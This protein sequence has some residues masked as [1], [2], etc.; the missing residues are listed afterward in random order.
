MSGFSIAFA[1]L[2]AALLVEWPRIQILQA[3]RARRRNRTHRGLAEALR[4]SV[5][6]SAMRTC[7][8]T[9]PLHGCHRVAGCAAAVVDA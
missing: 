2:V 1:L 9:S 4:P 3:K 5:D 6:E 7:D 8:A